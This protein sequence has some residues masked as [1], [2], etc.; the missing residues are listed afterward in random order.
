MSIETD[1]LAALA[2]HAPLVALVGDRIAQDAL[3]P[4][5]VYP[6]VV[7]SVRH[8]YTAGLKGVQLADQASIAVQCWGETGESAS[9]TADAVQ[10][11]VAA[12]ASSAGACTL[13]RATTF[14]DE[15]GLDGVLLE[16]EW[17]A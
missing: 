16:V 4:G 3:P 1:F 6:V 10:A 7:Y 14:D 11:A 13:G 5:E 15:T 17:W 12:V 2:A 8:D 9:A